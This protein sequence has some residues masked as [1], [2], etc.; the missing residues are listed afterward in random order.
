M[1]NTLYYP[2]WWAVVIGG[3]LP[4]AYFIATWRPSRRWSTRQLDTGGWVPVIAALYLSAAVRGLLGDVHAPDTLAAG[5]IPLTIGVGID[6]V[7]WLR[8]VR[9]A[10]FRR[11]PTH[12]LRRSTD[13]CECATDEDS[14]TD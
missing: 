5:V 10:R 14:S 2:I 8:A 6:A 12:P 4:S 11:H 9:W 7:L 1:S 3:L 13:P